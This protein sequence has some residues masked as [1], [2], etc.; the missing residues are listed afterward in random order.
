MSRW[1]A[2]SIAWVVGPGGKRLKLDAYLFKHLDRIIG[3]I[4][5]RLHPDKWDGD[6]R[7]IKGAD[8]KSEAPVEPAPSR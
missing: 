3:A 4:A 5:S 8:G 6:A 1:M 7:S 2:K